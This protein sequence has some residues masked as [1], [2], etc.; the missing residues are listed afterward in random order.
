GSGGKKPGGLDV[1]MLLPFAD[2]LP[3]RLFTT[4]FTPP[5]TEGQGLTRANLRRAIGLFAKAGWILREGELRHRLTGDRMKLEI[6]LVSPSF[7][8]LTEPFVQNLQ[9]A[10]IDASMRRVDTAQFQRRVDEYDYDLVSLRSN[11]FPPP[12]PELRS[13]YGSGEADTLGGANWT[14]VKD[15][16]VDTLIEKVISAPDLATLKSA[17]R[18]LDRVLLWGHYVV[19]QWYNDCHRIA[20]WN[21]FAHPDLFPK[22]SVGFP[23]LWWLD[24]AKDARVKAA[25]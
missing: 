8:R 11:F 4:D 15:T 5:T 25:R 12:G 9:K 18:A 20:Y 3:A 1:T 16:V 7:E 21:R 17:S 22:Y 24:A 13:Y 14:G 6:L 19:P 23:G 10:G 2:K